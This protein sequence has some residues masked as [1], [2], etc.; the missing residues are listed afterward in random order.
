[1][2][3]GSVSPP[4][5]P[6]PPTK[7]YHK[8]SSPLL[9]GI[10]A[11]TPGG[12]ETSLDFMSDHS[13]NGG[14]TNKLNGADDDNVSIKSGPFTE[15]DDNVEFSPSRA[16]A[17]YRSKSH[18]PELQRGLPNRRGAYSATVLSKSGTNDKENLYA[19]IPADDQY[20]TMKHGISAEELLTDQGKQKRSASVPEAQKVIKKLKDVASRTIDLGHFGRHNTIGYMNP[21]HK[22]SEV[23]MLSSVFDD[24]TQSL[25]SSKRPSIQSN[26]SVRPLPPSPTKVR[27]VSPSKRKTSGGDDNNIYESIDENES[28]LQE[29]RASRHREK[30]EQVASI[31]PELAIQCNTIME[32]F[33]KIPQVIEMWN[34]AVC[35]VLPNFQPPKKGGIPPFTINP[36]YI[37]SYGKPRVATTNLNH[38]IITEEATDIAIVPDN[39]VIVEQPNEHRKL[40]VTDSVLV[41]MNRSLN[42]GSTS[43]E[44][45][46]ESDDADSDREFAVDVNKIPEEEETWP[47]TSEGNLSMPLAVIHQTYDEQNEY[48]NNDIVLDNYS[49]SDNSSNEDQTNSISYTDNYVVIEPDDTSNNDSNPLQHYNHV[50]QNGHLSVCQLNSLDSGISASNGVSDEIV[51]LH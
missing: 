22:I 12:G 1:M 7:L 39:E 9:L 17:R 26:A 32:S 49:H 13:R 34:D 29:L 42:Q 30:M 19:S 27:R 11:T 44:E 8:S 33:L 3:T 51:D 46:D 23:S 31:D 41:R 5:I 38:D 24:S 40:T 15:I 16:Q 18:T 2:I 45:S 25:P 43:S 6:P 35:S 37:I 21:V 28:W 47:D 20:L 14:S 50:V 48:Q 10:T 4:P 36:E